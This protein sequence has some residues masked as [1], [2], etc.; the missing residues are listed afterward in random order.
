MPPRSRQPHINDIVV[1]TWKDIHADAILALTAEE[2]QKQGSYVF[3]TYGILVRD[4]RGSDINH[5]PMVAVAAEKSED[6][7][8]RGVTFI[9]VPVV[10][11][12]ER[13]RADRRSGKKA[14]HDPIP[15]RG[16]SDT[17]LPAPE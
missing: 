11:S 2:I 7:T 12:V 8:F 10:I 14:N 4:D 5:D 9:P 15:S 1:C 6:G 3:S 17:P 16:A 13:V